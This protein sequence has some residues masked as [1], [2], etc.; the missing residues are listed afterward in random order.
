MLVGDDR[1][2]D[3]GTGPHEV[4]KT[5]PRDYFADLTERVKRG[6]GRRKS[7][8]DRVNDPEKFI[9]LKLAATVPLPTLE[10]CSRKVVLTFP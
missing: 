7:P 6:R 10:C 9:P 1:F 3:A 5:T 8:I 4:I 2:V